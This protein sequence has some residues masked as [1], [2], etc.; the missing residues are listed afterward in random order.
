MGISH[1][2]PTLF[3]SSSISDLEFLYKNTFDY[4]YIGALDGYCRNAV[5]TAEEKAKEPFRW[6]LHKSILDHVMCIQFTDV[7]QV[8]DAARN[9]EILRDRDDYD[10]AV[11]VNT[12]TTITNKLLSLTTTGNSGV[13]AG[14]KEQRSESHRLPMGFP[15][16]PGLVIFSG[17]QEEPIGSCSSG[18]VTRSQTHQAVSLHLPRIRPPILQL[19][20]GGERGGD[21]ANLQSSYRMAPIELK[22]VEGISY[23]SCS[24]SMRRNWELF[25]ILIA[26]EFRVD[27]MAIYWQG[28][29]LCVQRIL[30]FEKVDELSSCSPFLIHPGQQV[31]I[32]HHVQSGPIA[33]LRFSVGSETYYFMDF[34]MGYPE[35]EEGTRCN[36]GCC[37]SLDLNRHI[38]FL[39]VRLPVSKL[40]ELFNKKF[41]CSI[42]RYSSALVSD[43]RSTVHVSFWKGLQKAWGTGSRIGMTIYEC[44]APLL[45]IQGKAEE[46]RLVRRSYGDRHAVGPFE[47]LDRVGEVSYRLA[48]PPQLSHV[49]N[50][51]H[52]SYQTVTRQS[53]E[54]QD[55]PFSL[56]LLA[57]RGERII[58]SGRSL[59]RPRSLYRLLILIFFHDLDILLQSLL[60]KSAQE[61]RANLIFNK[62]SLGHKRI[63][64]LSSDNQSLLL[65][66]SRDGYVIERELKEYKDSCEKSSVQVF[67]KEI[68]NQYHHV[69]RSFVSNIR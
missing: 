20:P 51:F 10:R 21:E 49:H 52:V 39:S 59:G 63:S 30:H 45:E 26:D 33:T 16:G 37:R 3:Q 57:R 54:E 56:Q 68:L 15:A 66:Y 46:V 41:N 9:L 38:F 61:S 5:V 42:T 47:I 2:V 35:S 29:K 18:H 62:I 4:S 67:Y 32:E 69:S 36:L 17:L 24:E 1:W 19:I 7:A 28:T 50:V 12:I 53:H 22:R 43:R 44:L 25:R 55:Y 58:P 40:A 6:G 23:R 60:T 27:A 65:Q 13:D 48:L 11:V 8:A 64:T 34:D 14:P 31:K